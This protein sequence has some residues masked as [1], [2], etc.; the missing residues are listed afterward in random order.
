M[1]IHLFA[2]CLVAAA[3]VCPP[4]LAQESHN[5]RPPVP[6]LTQGG[7]PSSNHTWTLG[8]TGARGWF[9]N[10]KLASGV[11][12]DDARQILITDVA[13][14]S[15]A[16]GLLKPG[17]VITGI[18]GQPFRS[19]ARCAF[20]QAVTDA[21]TE[22]RAGVLKLLRWRDGQTVDIQLKLRILGAYTPTAP[23]ACEKS[24]LIF[25]QGCEA[26]ARRGFKNRNGKVQISIANDMNA[27]ALLAL[28]ASGNEA[29]RPLVAEYAR[30]VAD[31]RP[32][33]LESWGYAYET[34]FLAEYALATRDQS[35]MPGLKRLTLD[36]ARGASAVGTWGHRFAAPSGNLNGYGCM[37]QPGIPLTLAMV[38]AR[39]AGV[40]DPDLDKAIAVASAFLRQWV[41]RGAI[42]YGDHDAWPWHEDNG[43]CS[44]AAVL[45]DLLGDREAAAYYA[46]MATAAY[47][48]RESG[49]TGNYFN[50]LWALPGVSRCGPAATSAYFNQ[51]RWY[52]DLARAWDGSVGYV[53]I[54]GENS[55]ENWDCTGSYLLGYALPLKSLYI[56]G[57]RPGA[58]PVLTQ[59]EV[60]ET[61]AAGR[62]FSFF[63]ADRHLWYAD[64]PTDALL[65]GL[66][67]W[68]PAVR[69]RSAIALAH[70]PGDFLPQLV[71]LLDGNDPHGRYGACEAVANLGAKA[72]SLAPRIRALLNDRD[73]WLRML[74]ARAIPRMSQTIRSAAVPD[75]LNAALINDPSDRRQRLAGEVAKALFSLSPGT[76]EPA[77][78]LARSLDGVDRPLLHAALK[79]VI[80]NEDGL[81]RGLAA[82]I[83]PL[84][85]P[86]DARA[87]LPELVSA[88][89]TNAPSGEMFRYGVRYNGLDLLARLRITEGMALSI[90]LM[91]EFEWGSEVGRCIRPLRA[92]GGAA[93]PLIPRLHE[94]IAAMRADVKANNGD[95]KKL[96]RDVKAIEGLIAAIEAD[97]NPAPTQSIEAFTAARPA[98]PLR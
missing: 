95:T 57:R 10:W 61:I 9:W 48:E 12:N 28:V 91:N 58:A 92:Y 42:P 46:R 74:A 5:N 93:R 86:D 32:G 53:A 62:D 98:P 39:E 14:G 43:K 82:G 66:S 65:A 25:E 36:I 11:Q 71:E 72:D 1:N 37:N 34:L 59:T 80:S 16:A 3:L 7:Q 26:I 40:N 8:A 21:E 6:D 50:I 27:L 51:A 68:S 33:G 38:L 90:D 78:I 31:S 17:D 47:A 79:R 81:I 54:R 97:T 96:D 22:A 67:S 49:H 41:D 45:F 20:A 60:D 83:Y 4:V 63:D 73:P 69:Q 18:D 29:H 2:T 44:G 23:Y 64:R 88:I 30:A 85:T 15:P 76:G 55:Y 70:R 87:I 24:R 19:D 75:L 77:P 94:T 13:E 84:L 56:T 89:R 52:Y 35:V